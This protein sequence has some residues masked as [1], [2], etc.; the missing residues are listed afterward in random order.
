MLILSLKWNKSNENGEQQAQN[1]EAPDIQGADLDVVPDRYLCHPRGQ[2][3]GGCHGTDERG[4]YP[5]DQH[6]NCDGQDLQAESL[7]DSEHDGQHSV[8]IAVCIE[9]QRQRQSQHAEQKMQMLSRHSRHSGGNQTRQTAHHRRNGV[10][11]QLDHTG[12]KHVA[13]R[14]DG[15][16]QDTNYHGRAY[17]DRAHQKRGTC[18]ALDDLFVHGG[19]GAV[20]HKKGYAGAKHKR[21]VA[22]KYAPSY[23]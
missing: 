14:T 4:A 22:G 3:H 21:K 20:I 13:V 10:G 15:R 5:Q 8:E 7:S 6:G 23:R 18:V 12:W 1:R 19:G 9:G 16:C 11:R 2:Q 17:H